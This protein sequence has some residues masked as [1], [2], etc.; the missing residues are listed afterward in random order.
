M[1]AKQII[2]ARVIPWELEGAYGYGVAV[3]WSDRKHE[4]YAVGNRLAASREVQRLLAGRAPLNLAP[5][6][7]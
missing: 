6:P 4:A 7:E 5:K 3:T 1:S 2:N